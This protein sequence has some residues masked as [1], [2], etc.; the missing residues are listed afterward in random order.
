MFVMVEYCKVER[1]P[2][3][4]F[5]TV[6]RLHPMMVE[7]YQEDMMY[8]VVEGLVDRWNVRWLHPVVVEIYWD[9]VGYVLMVMEC[10]WDVVM[11][12]MVE[13]L[14]IRMMIPRIWWR[15]SVEPREDE[16][17]PE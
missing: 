11:D 17:Y 8:V 9:K 6:L 3:Q 14:I 13:L 10:D 7:Y 5:T 15:M 1:W 4:V 12:M 16:C 2:E